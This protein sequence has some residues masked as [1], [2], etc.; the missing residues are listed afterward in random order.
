MM[1]RATDAVFLNRVVNDPEVHSHLYSNEPLDM[2]SLVADRRNLVLNG[3]HGS[4][5]FSENAPGVAEI[6]TQVLPDGRG[7]W[8][9]EF[10]RQCVDY[11]FTRTG[12]NEVFTR[13]P[14]GN[15]AAAA[16]ARA[17]GA[18][19]EHR[20]RQRM[21][22]GE[23][24][25]VEI[26]SGRIQ[27]WIRI[28]GGLVERGGLFHEKLHQKCRA[29]GIKVDHHPQDDWHDRHVGAAAGMILGGQVI[30]GVVV[31]N[32]WATMAMAPPIR[33]ISTD[34]VIINITDCLLEVSG[35]DFEVMPCQRA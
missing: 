18:K 22:N 6:H 8:A 19:T 15:V 3:E 32:R 30:K 29:A 17:C 20:T 4:M 7:P 23:E 28:A 1:H 25:M 13:V 11:L 9:L 16:L 24:P 5:I 2:S 26:Y 34:P 27:D 12:V 21:P 35:D 10:A 33:V 31:F 14:E